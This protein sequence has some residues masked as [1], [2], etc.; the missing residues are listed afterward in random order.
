MNR[1][2]ISA[3]I[4]RARTV[5]IYDQN[6]HYLHSVHSGSEAVTSAVVNG[7]SLVVALASG[8]VQVFSLGPDRS[9]VLRYTR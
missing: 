2:A 6:G 8:R 7:D 5:E 4:V 1:R 3:K 9:P